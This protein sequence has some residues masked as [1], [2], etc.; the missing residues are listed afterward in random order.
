MSLPRL[1][2][3]ITRLEARCARIMSP[4]T[5]VIVWMADEDTHAT[6]RQAAGYAPEAV[7]G[8]VVIFVQYEE[9]RLDAP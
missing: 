6:A 4:A 5:P 1:G 9:T 8:R 3:R 2:A 7:A